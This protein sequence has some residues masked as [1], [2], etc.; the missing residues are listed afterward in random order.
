MLRLDSKRDIYI[1]LVFTRDFAPVFYPFLKPII[2][3]SDT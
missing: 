2:S 3:L 1:K